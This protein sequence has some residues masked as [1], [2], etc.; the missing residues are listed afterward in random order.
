MAVYNRRSQGAGNGASGIAVAHRPEK[1]GKI[2]ALISTPKELYV[3]ISNAKS[4]EILN[5]NPRRLED[6]L[7]A[8]VD[9]F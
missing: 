8:S 9:S 7:L 1:A 4:K 6:A 3:K 2:A 5:W